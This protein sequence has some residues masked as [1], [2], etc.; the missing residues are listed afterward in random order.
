MNLF[1]R[2]KFQI[3]RASGID[4]GLYLKNEF[5]VV[6]NYGNVNM[7]EDFP[8]PTFNIKRP[9]NLLLQVGQ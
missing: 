8:I 2:I 3:P 1:L 7:P 4:E 9:L 6:W 5:V